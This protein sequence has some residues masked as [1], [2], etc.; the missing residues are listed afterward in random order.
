MKNTVNFNIRPLAFAIALA[1]SGAAFAQLASGTL[2]AMPSVANGTVGITKPA[3]NVM[4]ITNTPGAI[5]NWSSFSIGS[6]SRVTIDQSG[7]P[8]S[9]MLNRVTGVDPSQIM[10]R[11]DSNGRV[12]LVNPN[13][14][15]FGAGSVV[16]AQG[17]IAS[18][19]DISN[20][21]FLAGNYLFRGTGAG[22]I[23]VESGA[24]ISTATRGP[25]GQVWLVADKIDVQKDASINTPNGQVMLAAG[26][27][28]QVGSNSLGNMT[29]AVATG[30][31]NTIKSYGNIAAQ[32]GAVGM[33][34]DSIV[35]SGQITSGGG[36]GEAL[37]TAARD[38]TVTN[39]AVINASGDGAEN[40]GR[41]TLNA[42]NRL[43]IDALA[44]VAADGGTLAGNGGQI[45]LIAYDL[46]VSP[47]TSGMGNVH[48]S[49]LAPGAVNGDVRVMTRS[50]PLD[51][52][53]GAGPMPVTVLSGS[54]QYPSVTHLA[55][56][57]SVVVWMSTEAPVNTIWDVR[58]ATVYMQRIDANGQAIGTR[59]QVG[60]TKGNQS[61][62]SITAMRDGGF[63][64]AWSDGRTGRREVWARSFGANG[65]PISTDMKVS[66]DVGDHDNIKV[67]TLADGRILTTWSG[68]QSITPLVIDVRGQLLD[69]KGNLVGLPF[70]I[71][72]TGS[73]D[74]G[75]QYRPEIA[76]LA[77][78]G[79][80]I[81]YHAMASGSYQADAYGRRFDRNGAPVGPEFT[82]AAS[83]KSDWRVDTKGL[84]D[85]GYIMVW[86]TVDAAGAN[87]LLARRYDARGVMTM[88]DTPVGY[89]PG[90]TGQSF[91]Q[92]ASMADGGYVIA[93]MSY[94][95][96]IGN[97]NA[98]AYAQRFSASGQPVAAPK[99]IAGGISAQLEPRIAATANNGYTVTW[100]SNQNGGALDIYAQRFDSPLQQAMVASSVNAE[101]RNRGY[102]TAPSLSNG[103][104]SEPVLVEPPPAIMALPVAEPVKLSATKPSSEKTESALNEVRR[105]TPT[106]NPG[107]VLPGKSP[108]FGGKVLVKPTR[109]AAGAIVGYRVS[110]DK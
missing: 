53:A 40:G 85:G 52:Q 20:A 34:A 106:G 77:D 103:P 78:G 94:Q 68:R 23:V 50:A 25:N 82:I 54:D 89:A 107:F 1:C 105:V 67:S 61:F 99:L 72:M 39:G 36:T 109:N 57:S 91:A 14:V 32:R 22:Q 51:V 79:F 8:A 4:Q 15:L 102:T 98:D 42:G 5:V 84:L 7:G 90:G 38:I 73:A 58:Y 74:K 64:V 69:A 35:H 76:P 33:F 108:V 47:V 46:Q 49:A 93:W 110:E 56:G 17:L 81:T 100:T 59:A 66:S 75:S 83:A 2:P 88:G 6:A 9:A 48:A 26:S 27:E 95:N 44:N 43:Q 70:T 55:D 104:V 37:I 28:L 65:L 19:R 18:T 97:S 45:N 10:G 24:Q 3:P 101:L 12:F 16:D 30:S 11:L 71:N 80:V 63:V 62:P 31:A 92:V 21:N 13:G 60:I 29:F 41:I 96:G 87:R 86:D